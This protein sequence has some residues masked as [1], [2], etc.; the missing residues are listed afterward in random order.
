MVT[1]SVASV[2]VGGTAGRERPRSRR[3][4]PID[5]G[6]GCRSVARCGSCSSS[7]PR[8][9]SNATTTDAVPCASSR[10]GLAQAASSAALTAAPY[11]PSERVASADRR[12]HRAAARDRLGVRPG[13]APPPLGA[14]GSGAP[15]RALGSFGG[16][17]TGLTGL[18][19][20]ASER[21]PR[22]P[23]APPSAR[24][25][26][27]GRLDLGRRRSGRRDGAGADCDRPGERDHHRVV[28]RRDA[29]GVSRG[30]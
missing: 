8:A 12:R 24:A 29:D 28:D 30:R 4:A 11:Q 13:V 27:R 1:G 15:A 22:G 19:L 3:A 9:M 7:R 16:G 17:F 25:A 26:V 5:R 23:R 21:G 6:S 10:Y 2:H 20:S 18:S 14:A